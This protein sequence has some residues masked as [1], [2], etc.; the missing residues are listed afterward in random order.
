MKVAF[1]L[2]GH[3]RTFERTIMSQMINI[4][5]PNNCDIFIATWDEMGFVNSEKKILQSY[6][7]P[8][9]EAKIRMIYGSRLKGLEIYNY[10]ETQKL[11]PDGIWPGIPSMFFLA[12]RAVELKNQYEKKINQHYNIVIRTRPDIGFHTGV[13]F[14]E[15]T[16]FGWS[17][18]S[19]GINTIF[20]EDW[21][22][23]GSAKSMDL[24]VSLWDML[25]EY[26]KM[27]LKGMPGTEIGI[28][29]E[30][31][32]YLH[33]KRHQINMITI[34]LATEFVRPDSEGFQLVVS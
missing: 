27:N 18:A 6:S 34:P 20:I 28:I 3:M 5:E 2:N 11:F 22:S 29:P 15:T 31:I 9:D 13:Q 23:I 26:C 14:D 17:I 16:D 30:W 12:K 25:P 1:C 10:N 7:D 4:I 32:L 33:L 8:V 24:Y 19:T 21:L